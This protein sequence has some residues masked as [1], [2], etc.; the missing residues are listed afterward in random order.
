M[1]FKRLITKTDKGVDHA[2][3]SLDKKNE[4][5]I[6][7]NCVPFTD[8]NSKISNTEI[9]NAIDLD[10]ILPI[11]TLIEYSDSYS[12]TSESLWQHYWDKPNDV[13]TDSG[14]FKSDAKKQKSA[15]T[16]NAKDGKIAAH[17]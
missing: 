12:K 11:Y 8:C 14:L 13:L 16:N 1:F 6:F 2:E 7:K 15:S 9:N 10:I 4:G 5:V 3:N 17:L